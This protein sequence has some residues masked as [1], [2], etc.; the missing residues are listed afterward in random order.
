MYR[1]IICVGLILVMCLA[2]FSA[3]GCIEALRKSTTL[4]RGDFSLTVSVEK[5]KI[6]AGE[7][8]KV[9]AEL[10]NL[11]GKDIPIKTPKPE[12]EVLEDLFFSELYQSPRYEGEYS[13]GPFEP[14]HELV[15]EKDA[16]I[17]KT[18][19]VCIEEWEERWEFSLRPHF[20]VGVKVYFYTGEQ[21]ENLVGIHSIPIVIRIR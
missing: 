6:S 21:Y 7:K 16:V 11:S 3:C 10:R 1:K 5:R 8:V 4:V 20:E 15:I 19:E 12:I 18:M 17:C 14:S 2:F 9:T 13:F